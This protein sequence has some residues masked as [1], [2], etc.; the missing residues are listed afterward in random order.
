MRMHFEPKHFLIREDDLN[1]AEPSSRWLVVIQGGQSDVTKG[2][3]G[4]YQSGHR[5]MLNLLWQ[6]I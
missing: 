2:K 4:G 1:S 5:A 6:G 3:Y